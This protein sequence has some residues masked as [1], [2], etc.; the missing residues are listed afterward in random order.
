MINLISMTGLVVCALA[1]QAGILG[2]NA[3][4]HSVAKQS[5]EDFAL[6]S[7]GRQNY[8]PV[9]YEKTFSGDFMLK[10]ECW[11]SDGY[12]CEDVWQARN[13]Q[14]QNVFV[15]GISDERECLDLHNQII[16]EYVDSALK[17]YLA[18]NSPYRP[19]LVYHCV[20]E[21]CFP[22]GDLAWI[23]DFSEKK[24]EEFKA[25]NRTICRFVT[26]KKTEISQGFYQSLS[27]T[28]FGAIPK[29]VENIC[30]EIHH[31]YLRPRDL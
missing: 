29:T 8:A 5:F 24:R 23:N 10:S 3:K 25:K 21:S 12:T 1:F 4:V 18:K 9:C 17:G 6:Q 19:H 20:D 7:R 13:G 26:S 27:A 30:L 14:N 22:I 2:L 28:V 16:G 31:Y 15:S 11:G